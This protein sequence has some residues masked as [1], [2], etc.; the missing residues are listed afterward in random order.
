MFFSPVSATYWFQKH[1]AINGSNFFEKYNLVEANFSSGSQYASFTE[2]GEY[3][4]GDRT[5]Y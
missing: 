2:E 3:P 5:D 4:F 1:A